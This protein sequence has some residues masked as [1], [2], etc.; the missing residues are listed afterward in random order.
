MKYI[1]YAGEF[2]G[3][4]ARVD[5]TTNTSINL[6]N[7]KNYQTYYFR[8]TAIDSSRYESG[9]SNEVKVFT[10]FIKPGD[11]LI[12]NGDF[13]S[14]DDYWTLRIGGGAVARGNVTS[15]G[16]YHLEITDGGPEIKSVQLRQY[17]IELVK[18]KR[19]RFEFDGRAANPGIV[20]AKIEQYYQPWTNY[21]QIGYSY[22]TQEMKHFSYYFNM[23]DQ[24]NYGA[25]VVFNCGTSNSDVFIDN[26]SLK[27][28]VESAVEGDDNA[29]PLDYELVGNHP[30]PFNSR[31]KI[32]YTVPD[33][34]DIKITIYNILGE[35]VEKTIYHNKNPG[36]HETIFSATSLS[37]GIYFCLM[38]ARSISTSLK[39]KGVRKMTIIN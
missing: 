34:S 10:K 32:R 6:T 33:R 7:L 19:Y 39:F 31:T 23:M 38:E 14:G 29:L 21:G 11:N 4:T 26:V 35:V 28:I 36:I 30:N 15:Q 20:D 2:P 18:G 12:L 3:P 22:F 25:R 13:S 1:I 24:S 5:S 16:E 27:E 37:S 9:Y 8:V 17:H